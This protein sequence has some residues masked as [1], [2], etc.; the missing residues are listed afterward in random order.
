M[1]SMAEQETKESEDSNLKR[2]VQGTGKGK[3]EGRK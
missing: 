2:K 3:E 1:N